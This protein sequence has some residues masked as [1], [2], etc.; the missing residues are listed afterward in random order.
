M[1]NT[2]R[3]RI[4]SEKY[5][6]DSSRFDS[7]LLEMA[8]E[9]GSSEILAILLQNRGYKTA[10]EATRF[11]RFETADFH[12]PFLLN[13]IESAVSRI[14]TAVEHK[15]KICVYGDYDVDGVTSV[16]TIPQRS[17]FPLWGS[18]WHRMPRHG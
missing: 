1:N 9:I 17:R 7:S 4:W 11:L 12:D 15:E 3:E 6:G 2:K 8:K 14:M 5:E 18:R 10:E 16:S 13:D